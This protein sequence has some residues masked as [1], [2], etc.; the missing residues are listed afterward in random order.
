MSLLI[1]VLGFA[2]VFL[3]LLNVVSPKRYTLVVGDLRKL[4]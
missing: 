1:G 2:L 3:V 4:P